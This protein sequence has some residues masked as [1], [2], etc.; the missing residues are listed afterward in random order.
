[1]VVSSY[2]S[3]LALPDVPNE[4]MENLK[5]LE[6]DNVLGKYGLYEAIDYTPIRQKNGET[7]IWQE[8]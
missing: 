6:Q 4:V 5:L 8:I 2:G 7:K 1:M 3:M